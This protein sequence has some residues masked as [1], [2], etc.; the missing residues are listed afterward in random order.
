MMK[1]NNLKKYI[2]K[3]DNKGYLQLFDMVSDDEIEQLRKRNYL[4]DKG[5]LTHIPDLFG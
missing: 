4:K 1:L 3:L 5:N 2:E